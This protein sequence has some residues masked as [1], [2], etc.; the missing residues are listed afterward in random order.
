[1]S[2]C[3]WAFIRSS[4]LMSAIATVF[5]RF[6]WAESFSRACFLKESDPRSFLFFRVRSRRFSERIRGLFLVGLFGSVCI[7]RSAPCASGTCLSGSRGL[8]SV[9][10]F[11]LV[12]CML[13]WVAQLIVCGNGYWRKME[14]ITA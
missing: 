14:F 13:L 3:F 7:F 1:M 12:V 4:G 9:L 5:A 6:C 2:F 11:G 8:V 10:P